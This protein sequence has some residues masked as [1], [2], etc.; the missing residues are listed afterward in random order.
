MKLYASY[1]ISAFKL[2]NE[3][4]GINEMGSRSLSDFAKYEQNCIEVT[5]FLGNEE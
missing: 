3:E 5:G 1:Y 2:R 4:W